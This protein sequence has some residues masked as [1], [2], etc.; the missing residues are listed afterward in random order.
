[1][2]TKI[3][4]YLVTHYRII[5][6]A[7]FIG[8]IYSVPQYIDKST[9]VDFQGIHMG[10]VKDT[11][12]YMTRVKD[13][14][15]GHIFLTNPYLYE[16]KDGAPMQ[17]WVPDY[18][19]AKPIQWF[20]LSIS[21]GFIVWTF[22]L[23]TI[24]ALL[25]YSILFIITKSKDWSI[26]GVA[27]LHLGIF[28]TK[29]LRLPPPGLT[30]VFWL[31]TL[32]CLLL[33][34]NK[35]SKRYILASAVSFGLLFSIYPYYWTFY[36]V[37]LA[38]FIFLS[39]LLRYKEI[40]YKKYVLIIFGGL[41]IGIPYFI[42]L[43]HS[44]NLPGYAESLARLGLIQTHFPSGIDSV[45][46]AFITV[47]IFL[48]FYFKKFITINQQNIFLFSG[49]L[50]AIIV[51]NQH[52]ITGKNVEFSS[53]YVLGNMFW[54]AFVLI[55]LLVKWL[56][57]QPQKLN[58]LALV[59]CSIIVS[60]MALYGAIGVINQQVVYRQAEDYIQNYGPIFDW[61]N[62]NALSDQV[63]FAN[64]DV[65]EYLPIHTSQN[66]YFSG[67]SILSFMTDAEVQNR[68]VINRYFDTFT[69]EYIRKSQRQIFGGYYVNEYGHNMS[70]NK[71]L[72]LL[73]MKQ[74]SYVMVP[75]EAVQKIKTLAQNIQKQSFEKEIKTYKVDYLVWDKFKNP[76][77]KIDGLNFLKK[78]Y[79]SGNLI[80]YKVN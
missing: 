3:R 2:I 12:F 4:S 24:L 62:K 21:T 25:S 26:L 42:P 35:G 53:H 19:L 34:I 64:D 32:L 58:K 54:C 73:G 57:K 70:K 48:F 52:L 1:M 68:F 75:D 38:V 63:V 18:I 51:V 65:S 16:H 44:S 49:V 6:L 74:S 15:D 17:F 67:G 55:Y 78:V 50:S 28:G 10:V 23:T 77:W 41:I 31:L 46:V 27:L 40:P 9:R 72:K 33:F 39:I 59:C 56:D 37:V 13:V 61:L 8:L 29:F 30:F 66:I 47:I 20:G 45:L 43:F 69:D 5:I 11:T 14:I 60:L 76:N 36:V 71:V 80:I 79:T 22:V 7:I